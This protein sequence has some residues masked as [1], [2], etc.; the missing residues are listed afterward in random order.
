MVHNGAYST[1]KGAYWYAE[2]QDVTEVV[3]TMLLVLFCRTHESPCRNKDLA[4]T[5]AD[6]WVVSSYLLRKTKFMVDSACW[7]PYRQATN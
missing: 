4:S 5:V 2:S 1:M 7:F 6:D 3:F